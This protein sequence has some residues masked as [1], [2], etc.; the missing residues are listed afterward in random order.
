MRFLFFFSTLFK[1]RGVLKSRWGWAP[2]GPMLTLSWHKCQVQPYGTQ[3]PNYVIF[4]FANVCRNMSFFQKKKEFTV[5][6]PNLTKFIKNTLLP[7]V[8][9]GVPRF[10][11]FPPKMFFFKKNAN[12]EKYTWHVS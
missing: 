6:F 1:R 5:I 7:G 4:F 8:D 9:M 3:S 2:K 10:F 11:S 12:Y